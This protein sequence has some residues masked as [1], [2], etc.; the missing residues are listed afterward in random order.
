[1]YVN[2]WK[3]FSLNMRLEYHN[4]LF[5]NNLT[6]FLVIVVTESYRYCTLHCTGYMRSWPS[7]QLDSEGDTEKETSNLTCLV[8]VCRLLPHASHQPSKD[9]NVK[10]AEFVTRCA[11]DGKFTF[12]DQRWVLS[13]WLHPSARFTLC[14]P[15]RESRICSEHMV[16]VRKKC[17]DDKE[18]LDST[19]LWQLACQWR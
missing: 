8:T 4:H 9:V 19:E 10:P 14:L 1:M 16:S 3:L 15:P 18:V 13:T 6:H 7:S 5:S 2:C 12:V 11:I 17:P